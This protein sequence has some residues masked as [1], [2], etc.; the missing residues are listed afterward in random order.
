[1]D[2]HHMAFIQGRLIFDATNEC[3]DTTLES[4]VPWILLKRRMTI[5][6]ESYKDSKGFG[7]RE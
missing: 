4:Q 2:E 5:S 6:L 7:F 3:V 1:M